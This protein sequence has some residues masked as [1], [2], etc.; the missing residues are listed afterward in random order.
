MLYQ[1][2][3][4]TTGAMLAMSDDL[5]VDQAVLLRPRLLRLCWNPH[6]EP[7]WL[8]SDGQKI[9]LG[10]HQAIA[11]TY[12]H[13]LGWDQPAPKLTALAFNREFYCMQQHDDEVSCYGVLFF[14]AQHLPVISLPEEEARAVHLLYEV[15]AEEFGQRDHVQG[16]V[17]LALLK[18]LIVR[19][20]RIATREMNTAQL[21][22]DKFDLIRRFHF[23]VD[24][25]YKT[26]REVA[27]Y[28]D[29]LHKS[30]KTL[31][32]VFRLHN[33]RSPQQVIHERIGLEAKRLLVYT[34]LT[35]KE[36]AVELGFEEPAHFSKFFKKL[37]G[38]S[39]LGFRAAGK[40]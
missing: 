14:G 35:V 15:L 23:L 9:R 6:P 40:G 29:L 20:T 10:Q 33:H 24:I 37:Y 36:I 31:S 3:Q 12:L 32:N 18:R 7:A 8:Y 2:H 5:C 4:T 26:C 22:P 17:L 19:V 34:D 28:A 38:L 11:V 13:R 39:P 1:Y 27:D 25:H 21:P 16:E 30:P